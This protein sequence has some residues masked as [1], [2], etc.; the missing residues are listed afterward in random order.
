MICSTVK[1]I[2]EDCPH[3][4]RKIQENGT[5]C[6]SHRIKVRENE[7]TRDASSHPFYDLC[8]NLR[9]DDEALERIPSLR[10]LPAE[11]SHRIIA[12]KVINNK[13]KKWTMTDDAPPFLSKKNTWFFRKSACT[14]SSLMGDPRLSLKIHTLFSDEI[15]PSGFGWVYDM[16][17]QY[18]ICLC[19]VIVMCPGPPQTSQPP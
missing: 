9:D 4:P 13:L 1:L 15:C 5:T 17:D 3:K 8:Q 11:K 10:L 18:M 12:L 7:T 19:S 16:T 14:P 6:R 2:H